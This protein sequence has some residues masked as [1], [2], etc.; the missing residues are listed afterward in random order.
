MSGPN[1]KLCVLRST[2]RYA[3]TNYGLRALSSTVENDIAYLF[4]YRYTCNYYCFLLSARPRASE[5]DPLPRE[6]SHVVTVFVFTA[7]SCD[8][9]FIRFFFRLRQSDCC[10]TTFSRIPEKRYGKNQITRS[11]I[12]TAAC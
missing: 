3:V 5:R 11:G 4:P 12:I 8:T 9:I 10:S 2:S 6:C 7:F 1:I